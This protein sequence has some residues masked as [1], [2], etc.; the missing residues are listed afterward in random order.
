MRSAPERALGTI[1]RLLT[2]GRSGPGGARRRALLAAATALAAAG[3]ASMNVFER[4]DLFVY[5][6]T[7][8]RNGG[9]WAW[10]RSVHAEA[11]RRLDQAGARA[12]AFDVVFAGP[13]ARDPAADTLLAGAMREHAGVVLPILHE[14]LP[15]NGQLVEVLPAQ[16]LAEAAAALAHVEVEEDLDG[17]VR[18]SFLKGGV[19]T[20]H[21]PALALAA[22]RLVKPEV[23][24]DLP[25]V[26]RGENERQ[27]LPMAWVRDEM[28][29]IPYAG[30]G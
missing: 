28:I 19:A 2:T 21:W 23:L 12:I 9:P 29:L 20:P 18:R 24:L 6:R 7:V 10:K 3:A 22:V 25:V 15:P 14:Q 4:I 11:V 30:P 5:D 13:D 8:A 27:V 26:R 16:P 17:V 1:R